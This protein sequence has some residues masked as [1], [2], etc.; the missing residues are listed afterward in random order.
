MTQVIQAL[1]GELP[2]YTVNPDVR[3][4]WLERWGR[5]V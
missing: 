3:K 1:K 2:A 5:K 4:K